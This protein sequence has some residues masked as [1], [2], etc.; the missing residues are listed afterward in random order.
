MGLPAVILRSSARKWEWEWN[1]WCMCEMI[2]VVR[3][4]DSALSVVRGLYGGVLSWKGMA[5]GE[6]MK[7][8]RD[9]DIEGGGTA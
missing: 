2:L 4:W 5:G 9:R 8:E 1:V 6:P 7:A 3:R